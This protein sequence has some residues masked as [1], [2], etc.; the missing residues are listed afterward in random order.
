[1]KN[2]LKTKSFMTIAAASVAAVVSVGFLSSKV[3]DN[4]IAQVDYDRIVQ[5]DYVTQEDIED[6]KAESIA[7]MVVIAMLMITDHLFFFSFVIVIS[8]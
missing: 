7:E 6:K 5:F 2:F 4:V 3:S 1:M 8:S